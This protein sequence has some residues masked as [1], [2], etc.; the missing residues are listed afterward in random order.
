MHSEKC[1]PGQDSSSVVSLAP[2]CPTSHSV[3]T[4]RGKGRQKSKA[5]EIARQ[6][7]KAWGRAG[8]HCPTAALGS[9]EHSHMGTPAKNNYR[10][11]KEERGNPEKGVLKRLLCDLSV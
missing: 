1:S 10:I 7:F 8:F 4:I 6:D 3:S 9:G 2:L 11:H 5:V